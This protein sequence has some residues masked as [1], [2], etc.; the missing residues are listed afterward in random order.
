ML[1]NE[2]DV[3]FISVCNFITAARE[4]RMLLMYL[5]FQLALAYLCGKSDVLKLKTL[6]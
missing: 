6:G 1:F 5:I 3:F 4:G 2:S